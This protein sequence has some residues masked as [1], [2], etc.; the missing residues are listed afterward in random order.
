MPP[1]DHSPSETL[2]MFEIVEGVKDSVPMSAQIRG[3]AHAVKKQRIIALVFVRI[4]LVFRGVNGDVRSA[5]SIQLREKQTEPV[6]MFV[7]NGDCFRCGHVGFSAVMF[8]KALLTQRAHSPSF[9]LRSSANPLRP[10]R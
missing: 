8:V 6:G 5:A 1:I 10:L 2:E 9:P 4:V 3:W 7:V